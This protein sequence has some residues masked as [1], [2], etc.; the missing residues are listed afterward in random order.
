MKKSV[1][2]YYAII[3]H[4]THCRTLCSSAKETKK[5]L[6]NLF[7]KR[8]TLFALTVKDVYDGPLRVE[9]RNKKITKYH[10][11]DTIDKRCVYVAFG[12]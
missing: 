12:G 3:V 8:P 7:H 10:E 1:S 6:L 2:I 9:E 4:Y 5:N 11:S